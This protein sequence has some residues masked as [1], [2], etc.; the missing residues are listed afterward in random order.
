MDYVN[1]DKLKPYSFPGFGVFN[2]LAKRFVISAFSKIKV[3]HLILEDNGEVFTF[4][5]ALSDSKYHAHIVVND[6]SAYFDF[7]FNGTTGSGEAYMRQCWT[8]PDLLS[9]VRLM[10]A[11]LDWLSRLNSGRPLLSRLAINLGGFLKQNTPS[12]SKKNIA[13]HY[14][15]G[16]E[17][18]EIFLDPTMMYSSAIY[19]SEDASLEEASLHKLKV[20]CEKLNLNSSDHLLEIGTGWGGMAIYAAQNYGC[21]VTTT[22]ISKEQYEFTK[23]RVESLCLQDRITLLLKDYRE[24][25]GKYDKIVS[26]EM[27]EAVG[28]QFYESYFNVCNSLLKADGLM[29]IQAITIADQRY[30]YAKSSVDF[31]KK[32]IFPGGCLP[33]N[34]VIARSLS[35]YTDMQIIDLH[36]ITEHYARTLDDW[37]QAFKLNLDKIKGQS[38]DSRFCRMWEFYLLYCEGGFKERVI[39]TCQF[40]FAKPGYR[41]D[42]ASS[43]YRCY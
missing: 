39:S 25:D 29:V 23:K 32:Y 5:Q 21:K 33:S 24:L 20:I 10:V 17:F 27:I 31:I 2:G 19:P 26:I 35:R 12:G 18:F 38:F 1:I 3:G 40:V 42:G 34:E 41:S 13:A 8:S 14:D 30:E 15:L 28:Y 11:N 16:N 43:S 4:G 36:D 37:Y 9:V 22:T 6:Q 7:F